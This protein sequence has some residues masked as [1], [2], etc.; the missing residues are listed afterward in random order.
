MDYP[1]LSKY[2]SINACS[3]DDAHRCVKDFFCT[4]HERLL[5]Y[6]GITPVPLPVFRV[7]VVFMRQ[8][9]RYRHW[10]AAMVERMNQDLVFDHSEAMR[11]LAFKPRSF[12]L[13]ELD[14]MT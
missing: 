14:V 2:S 6:G 1:V 11:D 9:P 5:F 8:L 10:S 13:S 7:A 12:G 4:R 3:I